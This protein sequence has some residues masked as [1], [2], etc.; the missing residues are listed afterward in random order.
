MISLTFP[1]LDSRGSAQSSRYFQTLS[2]AQDS[3]DFVTFVSAIGR[4]IV[5]NREQKMEI[6]VYLRT[7]G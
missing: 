2:S 4:I 1:L 7:I 3:R 6:P 5:N